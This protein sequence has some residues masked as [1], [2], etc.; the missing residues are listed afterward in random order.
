MAIQNYSQNTMP[1]PP[2]QTQQAAGQ[3]P[4]TTMPMPP[5]PNLPQAGAPAPMP[6]PPPPPGQSAMNPAPSPYQQW[7]NNPMNVPPPGQQPGVAPPPGYVGVTPPDGGGQYD[8][9]WSGINPQEKNFYGGQQIAGA[10][11]SQADYDSVRGYADQ[12]YGQARRNLDPMQEQQGRRMEQDLVNKGIDPSS[13][14]GKAM[15]DQQNRNFSDQNSKAMFDSLG[16]GQGIQNQ[17]SQQELANQTL[18][19]NMQQGL[20]NQQLGASGQGLQ[21]ELGKMGNQLGFAGL[22]NQRY[23]MELQNQLGQAGIAQQQYATDMSQRLGQAGLE[24]QRYGMDL[25][26]QLGMGQ[27]DFQRNQG[28]HGQTMDWLNYDKGISDT[29]FNRGIV[30]DALYNQMYGATPIPGMGS[31]NPYSP[32]NSQMGAGDTTWWQG[33]GEASIGF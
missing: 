23:G 27:L 17:M 16:F 29:N 32:A 22:E 6:P 18:A 11:P 15:L 33:G 13:D 8:P 21:Y 10:T 20:W 30:Q 7:G 14:Q 25:T 31:V 1:M 24:N 19:G 12:A 4:Q 3:P 2:H 9:N 28:E 5:N 26:N